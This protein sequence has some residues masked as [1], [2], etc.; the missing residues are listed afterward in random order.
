MKTVKNVIILLYLCNNIA[1]ADGKFEGVVYSQ[2]G[3][4]TIQ[5]ILV[6]RSHQ[7]FYMMSEIGK[8]G[9]IKGAEITALTYA[10]KNPEKYFAAKVR[11][12]I[13]E[14]TLTDISNLN[15]DYLTVAFDS[16]IAVEENIQIKLTKRH[17]YKGDNLVILFDYDSKNHFKNDTTCYFLCTKGTGYTIA[18]NETLIY[19]PNIKIEFSFNAV[20][21]LRKFDNP[22]GQWEKV[23]ATEIGRGYIFQPPEFNIDHVVWSGGMNDF[24]A[25]S[26]ADSLD[27]PVYRSDAGLGWNLISHPFLS[28]IDWNYLYRRGFV[29][30]IDNCYWTSRGLYDGISGIGLNNTTALIKFEGFWVRVNRGEEIGNITFVR[31]AQKHYKDDNATPPIYNLPYIKIAFVKNN[32]Q[33]ESAVAFINGTNCISYS[34]EKKFVNTP[35]IQLYTFV[36]SAITALTYVD[37]IQIPLRIEVRDGNELEAKPEDLFELRIIE[38]TTNYTVTLIDTFENPDPVFN[39]YTEINLS[40]TEVYRFSVPKSGLYRRFYIKIKG[41]LTRTVYDEQ[42]GIWLNNN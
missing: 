39:L 28:Y 27:I 6:N 4:D 2:V 23:N 38:N 41:N 33:D 29:E 37:S 9:G 16:T 34:R 15:I 31:A 30:K 24:Y 17:L 40:E 21:F 35:G 12:L 42:S 20:E 36:N 32:I 19:N 1:L 7:S 10:V 5:K 11:I 26:D 22:Q 8:G 25:F 14:T 13:G 18:S 3:N